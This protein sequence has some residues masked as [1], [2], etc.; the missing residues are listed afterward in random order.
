MCYFLDDLISRTSKV[1]GKKKREMKQAQ[2]RMR[3]KIKNIVKELHWKT[4]RFL[5]DNFDVILFSRIK[6]F[7]QKLYPRNNF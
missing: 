7:E 1:V 2:A 3:K 5:V 4:A 6:F